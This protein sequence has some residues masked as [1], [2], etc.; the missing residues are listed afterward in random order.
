MQ[1]KAQRF[2]TLQEAVDFA[3]SHDMTVLESE[4]EIIV[5][6]PC[7]DRETFMVCDRFTPK[8]IVDMTC[9]ML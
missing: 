3:R 4:T 2:W 1:S 5:A 9:R 8:R 6:Y 7:G